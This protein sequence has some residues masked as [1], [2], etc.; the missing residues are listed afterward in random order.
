[1]TLL[2]PSALYLGLLAAFILLL[3]LFRT[4]ER[5]REVSAL[6]LWEGLREDLRAKASK[7]RIPLDLLLLLQIATLLALV[8]ALAQP[9]FRTRTPALSELAIILD[10][11]A[12]MR[13]TIEPDRSRYEEASEQATRLIEEYPGARTTVIQLSSRAR[14]LA[15]RGDSR[16]EVRSALARS[17]PTANADGSIEDLLA[18]LGSVGGL[19]S[20]QRVVFFSDR[21][22]PAALDRLEIRLVHGGRNGS[23][24][25][26][27]AREN[28]TGPGVLVFLRVTNHTDGP[29]SGR[30]RIDDGV[31]DVILSVPL[32]ANAS[33]T[34]VVPFPTSR[35]SMFTAALEPDDDFR[36]DNVRYFALERAMDLRVRWI[37]EPN[38][39]LLAAL[40]SVV[41]IALVGGSED[42][43]LTVVYDATVPDSVSGNVLLIHG[44][45]RGVVQIGPDGPGGDVIALRPDHPLL[46]G[47]RPQSFRIATIPFT[48]AIAAG[49]VV[50]ASEETPLLVEFEDEDR[51]ITFIA[52]DLVETNLPIT[53][54]FPILI[55]NVAARLVRLPSPVSHNWVVVGEPISLGEGGERITSIAT[56]AAREVSLGQEQMTFVPDAP[57][58]Y[59]L[60]SARG[61]YP[62]AVNVSASESVAIAA[63]SEPAGSPFAEPA[64]RMIVRRLWGALA[65]IAIL[66]LLLEAIVHS[67]VS[68]PP[69]RSR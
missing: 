47:I 37:G 60:V 33:E 64:N 61:T 6:F 46:V 53:V 26:F 24:D 34:F 68:L 28:P 2:N 14:V 4:K 12:S 32:Q 19:A 67:G 48:E 25:A 36:D 35:G 20:F 9:A 11:S 43:D 42:A 39:Y 7:R 13:T 41:P 45:M 62:L 57:G 10:G 58:L 38:R 5:R 65:A 50:L 51:T 63:A 3:A 30:V 17:A 56:P 22:F 1:M 40:E 15:D 16:A 49:A 52:P 18:V 69:W 21:A 59:R 29:L 54:D 31:S 27:S 55:R 66:C 23:I 8:L 44:E